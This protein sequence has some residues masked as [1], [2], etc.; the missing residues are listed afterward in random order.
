MT[1]VSED[2]AVVV[3]EAPVLNGEATSEPASSICPMSGEVASVEQAANRSNQTKNGTQ[4]TFKALT[5]AARFAREQLRPV[6]PL[7]GDHSPPTSL[8]EYREN[9]AKWGT[10][11]LS[12]FGR[13]PWQALVVVV[14]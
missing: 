5:R 14:G 7:V 2:V 11:Q 9:T 13:H 3:S 10:P 6:Y 8:R 4:R 1:A 12:D